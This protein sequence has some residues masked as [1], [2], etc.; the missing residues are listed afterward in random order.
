MTKNVLY[1]PSVNRN[2]LW[3]KR[4]QTLC[5]QPSPNN[6]AVYG[7]VDQE[8]T[9][10]P[11][12]MSGHC[13]HTSGRPAENRCSIN[14]NPQPFGRIAVEETDSDLF[15]AIDRGTGKIGRLLG[16]ELERFQDTRVDGESVRSAPHLEPFQ[17]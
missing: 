6:W 14:A 11:T 8:S 17:D 15:A 9:F 1:E 16:R 10:R 3:P 4:V 7:F 2:D 5:N 12:C 13:S